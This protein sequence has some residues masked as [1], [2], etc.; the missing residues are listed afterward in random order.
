MLTGIKDSRKIT[1]GLRENFFTRN[2]C[3]LAIESQRL[4]SICLTTTVKRMLK[5]VVRNRAKTNI[6]FFHTWKAVGMKVYLWQRQ[7]SLILIS[8]YVEMLF[9]RGRKI[10]FFF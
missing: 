6:N 7:M 4:L 2:Y 10:N 8:M 1:S 9:L 3:F 5:N